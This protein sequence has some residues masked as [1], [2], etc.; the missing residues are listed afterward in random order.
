MKRKEQN[1]VIEKKVTQNLVDGRRLSHSFQKVRQ[2]KA[3]SDS[4]QDKPTTSVRVKP[5]GLW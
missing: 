3:R 4:P 5:S 1:C 2:I